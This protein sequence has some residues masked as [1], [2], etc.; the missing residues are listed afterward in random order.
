MEKAVD[1]LVRIKRAVLSGHFVFTAKARIE[2][3]VDR[4]T[5]EDVIESLV[6]AL[7]IYKRIRSTS[8]RK[9]APKEYLYVIQSATLSGLAIYSKGKLVTK[10]G[11]D[12]YYILIS[13]KRAL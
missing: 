13:A 10:G 8:P 3:A 11:V 7:A 5:E 1:T 12:T 6:Y 2:M 4:I 9:A